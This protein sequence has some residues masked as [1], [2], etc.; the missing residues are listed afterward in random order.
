MIRRITG[1]ASK[2]YIAKNCFG[3]NV[4]CFCT[5]NTDE[6]MSKEVKQVFDK[7][8]K[9]DMIQVAELSL[10]LQTKFNLPDLSTMMMNSG[11]G[12]SNEQVEKEE[13]KVEKTS[14][15]VKLNSFDA[16]SKIKIIKE[17]RAITGLGL[18][19]AKALVE[20]APAVLKQDVNK[21]DA[22]KLVES[23]SKLT[24]VVTLE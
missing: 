16:K 8:V 17:V 5:V 9:L 7:I 15:D 24:A 1:I 6:E 2:K 14:F 13:E 11:G 20:S 4:K 3:K 22:D 18:K 19:E 21:E 10:A 23:L 12:S